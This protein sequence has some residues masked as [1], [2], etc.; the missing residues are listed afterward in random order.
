MRSLNK[1][2]GVKRWLFQWGL[3]LTYLILIGFGLA[4]HGYEVVS[5]SP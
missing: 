2:L 5:S 4:D 1:P 3:S